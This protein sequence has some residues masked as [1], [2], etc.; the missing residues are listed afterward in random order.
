MTKQDSELDKRKSQSNAA[1][2]P[3]RRWT[4]IR[5]KS[6][7]FE[8]DAVLVLNKPSSI[9]V[10]GDR[11]EIDLT[12]LAHDAGEKLMP[13]HRVDKE[14]SGVIIF[15]KEQR[16]HSELTRQFHRRSVEKAYLAITRSQGLP[17]QGVIDLPLSAGRKKRVRVGTNR[18]NIMFDKSR[19]YWSVAPS[20]VLTDTK[21]YPSITLFAN[22][23]E[24]EHNTL[25]VI[26]PI[27]GRRHQIRVHL[28]WIGHPIYGDPLFDRDREL[29][30]GR[31][32]LHSWRI[33]FD[34]TW[35]NNTRIEVEAAPGEDF[36][37]IVGHNLPG[38]TPTTII[39]RAR[40]AIEKL[41]YE[42][43]N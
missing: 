5:K 17:D 18:K 9:S 32:L 39:I 22:V 31:T 21:T 4:E 30:V 2:T 19:N 3:E 7:V 40:S 29:S 33:A 24:S 41:K 27:T 28:A 34:A 35:S 20:D 13:V 10:V 11:Q 26:R 14:T 43:T 15:A 8:D 38:G 36:W 6:V 37:K 16:V 42:K 12:T 23:W 25:L 1:L